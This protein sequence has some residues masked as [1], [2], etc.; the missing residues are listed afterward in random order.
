[1]CEVKHEDMGP[2]GICEQFEWLEEALGFKG[3]VWRG[4]QGQGHGA[5][6]GELQVWT[7]SCQC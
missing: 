1:M 6:Y 5:S 4:K 2:W 3:T 7:L